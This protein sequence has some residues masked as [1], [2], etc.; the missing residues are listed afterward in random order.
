MFSQIESGP[1]SWRIRPLLL[2]L[3]AL[4]LLIGVALWQTVH[5]GRQLA[6]DKL[7][8]SA[9]S[10][11][12]RYINNLQGRLEKYE[13][14]PGVLADN[15]RLVHLLQN[16][17]DQARID[18]LNRYLERV[19]RITGTSDTYLMDVDGLTIAASN[20]Q[21]ERPFVG[22]NFSYRPYFQQ[23]MQ[24]H[25]GR[26]FALGTTSNKRGY[27]FAYPVRSDNAI[28]G[29]VVIKINMAPIE[30]SW[31]RSDAE[32]LVT[33]PD[34]VI[35]ITTRKEWRFKTLGPVSR[36]VAERIQASRRYGDAPLE[37]LP[38]RVIEPLND[39]ARV[40]RLPEPAAS[41]YLM[42]E[43]PMPQAGWKVHILSGL[44]PVNAQALRAVVFAALLLTAGVLL[45]LF[46]WQRRRRLLDRA[47]FE[48][49]AKQTL[50]ARVREQTRDLI[51]SNIRL[52]REI[53]EHRRTGDQLQHT[54]DELIQAAKLAVIG[55][56][57]T[58]ISQPLA[59]I[60]SYAQNAL[61]LL[62]KQRTEDVAW[63]LVQISDL[64]E[65]M[66]Q[67][68]SQ[69]KLFARKTSGRQAS[70]LLSA[71]IDNSLK[72]LAPRL[73]ETATEVHCEIPD[74]CYLR[75]NMVQL[76]QVLVNL[77]G[78]AI[79]AVESSDRRRIVLSAISDDDRAQISIHDS[80][81][82]IAGEHIGRIFDPF[83]TTKKRGLG[84]GLGLSISQRI[85]EGMNGSLSARNHPDGGAEF[86]L[87]MQLAEIPE[88]EP[89]L[90]S[91]SG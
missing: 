91:G 6:L 72:I 79:H 52:K 80:G 27:Y 12:H 58:G 82:G 43:R 87:E 19:N 50:Q 4:T 17:G 75:A 64:T 34:G 88:E 28:L 33:D 9:G 7:Q 85:V 29:A 25:L 24:G 62:E 66:A 13:F 21:S 11:L 73:K 76:E 31:A 90:R 35:F 5:W 36:E 20:W 2:L 45:V 68:S 22:R 89:A 65:R 60:R 57:S 38:L 70:V 78:N 54:Q 77:I 41:D 42:Q 47:R 46:W 63:N 16:P 15:K 67:I 18:A 37:Q 56:L 86:T 83:F 32:F 14:L 40:V 39:V 1:A 44:D 8:A 30:Q 48:Q 61:A 26:Y 71:A 74:E 53:E 23:A 84:L 69:L 49:Q 59:A 10:E 3:A 51:D 81:P 55:Q